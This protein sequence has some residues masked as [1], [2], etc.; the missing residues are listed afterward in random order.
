[1]RSAAAFLVLLGALPAAAQ[2]VPHRQEG[3][4]LLWE[5]Q[6]GQEAYGVEWSAA[7]SNDWQVDASALRFIDSSQTRTVSLPTRYR[8][9]TRPAAPPCPPGMALIPAGPFQMGDSSGQGWDHERPVHT[10]HVSAFYMDRAEAG[11]GQMARVMQWALGQG[12]IAANENAAVSLTTPQRVLLDTSPY[13][14][15]VRPQLYFEEGRFKVL[16]EGEPDSKE[17][18]PCLNMTR[19]GALAFCNY[20]S[21]ID[22]LQP[23]YNVGAGTCNFTKNGYRLPT[24]A[25]W[26]KAARGGLTGHHYPWPSEG[27]LYY[28]HINGSKANYDG[29]GDPFASG[30]TWGT[31]PLKYYNGSQYPYGADMANGYG[32][33]DMA[34]N[35]LEMCW[36]YY[37]EFWY[38]SPEASEAD[39]RGPPGGTSYVVRGGP[40]NT[41]HAAETRS[42]LRCAFRTGISLAYAEV[43][44]P[45]GNGGFR[46]VRAVEP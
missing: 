46:C 34:G 18:F 41:W 33:Y 37:D 20:R 27:G 3:E 19:F 45:E 26:E 8:V 15:V 4:D 16:D 21:E 38:G 1:M 24:E 11:N 42:M 5:H 23:C 36:D 32:L 22:G 43:R 39:T 44:S 17:V 28:Y 30:A 13:L 7:A 29:S 9:T 35:V 10:V 40:W 6:P 31:T 2:I 12:R 25:E 14:G